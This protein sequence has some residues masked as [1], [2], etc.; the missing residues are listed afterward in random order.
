MEAFL[1]VGSAEASTSPNFRLNGVHNLAGRLLCTSR[2]QS[3]FTE[4]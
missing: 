4:K 2:L 1:L 3:F